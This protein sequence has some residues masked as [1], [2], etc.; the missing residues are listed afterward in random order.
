MPTLEETYSLAQQ[1]SPA[2]RLRLAAM[3]LEDVA[4]FLPAASPSGL[5][6]YSDTWTAE[7]VKEAA[8]HSARYLDSIYPEEEDYPLPEDAAHAQAR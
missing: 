3:L 1:M 4:Q 6:G 7:D 8:A 2:L 5:E